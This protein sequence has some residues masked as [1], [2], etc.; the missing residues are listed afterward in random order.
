MK[1]EQL[2][3][4]IAANKKTYDENPAGFFGYFEKAKKKSVDFVWARNCK[5]TELT[6]T[7][8]AVVAS[9]RKFE[10]KT[11]YGY[12]LDPF[13][14]DVSFSES[15]RVAELILKKFNIERVR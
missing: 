7:A 13:G 3:Y 14:E 8:R 4:G 1:A 11:W 10:G 15:N 9:R 12:T 6:I 2:L 5:P